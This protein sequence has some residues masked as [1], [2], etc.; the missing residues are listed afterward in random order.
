MEQICRQCNASGKLIHTY[1]QFGFLTIS[2]LVPIWYSGNMITEPIHYTMNPHLM[3]RNKGCDQHSASIS[4]NSVAH[5]GQ[6]QIPYIYLKPLGTCWAQLGGPFLKASGG[7]QNSPFQ[8]CDKSPK[9]TDQHTAGGSVSQLSQLAKLSLWLTV[10]TKDV[11]TSFCHQN[12]WFFL[13]YKI[14]CLYHF[15]NP[16]EKK[17][18]CIYGE[19]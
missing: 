15:S 12:K 9:T 17:N 10:S 4:N 1:E 19:K 11:T 16:I 7:I 18:L 14:M 6:C 13:S 8:L 2:L 5:P 3:A